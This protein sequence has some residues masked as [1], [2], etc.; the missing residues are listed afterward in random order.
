MCTAMMNGNV[1]LD[2]FEFDLKVRAPK[3][4]P[5]TIWTDAAKRG[6]APGEMSDRSASASTSLE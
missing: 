1:K 5:P 3:S 2:S 6:T 4:A